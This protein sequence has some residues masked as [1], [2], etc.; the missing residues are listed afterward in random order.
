MYKD[1]W[2]NPTVG[3]ELKFQHEVG[4]SHDPLTVA[5]LKQID[6]HNTIVGYVS[7]R[8]S[9]YLPT[10]S[11]TFHTLIRASI[12]AKYA[13]NIQNKPGGAYLVKFDELN[14]D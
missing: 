8:I 13:H 1:I 4:N 10:V 12:T 6:E 7:Q 11:T 5:V 2:E 9:E 14:I 3:E